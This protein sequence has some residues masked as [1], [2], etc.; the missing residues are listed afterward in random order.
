MKFFFLVS[1]SLGNPVRR[2]ADI[3]HRLLSEH[4]LTWDD[5]LSPLIPILNNSSE[6]FN[7][8]AASIAMEKSDEI[9]WQWGFW[10]FTSI[11]TSLVRTGSSS[12][13]T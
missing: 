11:T 6:A 4:S 5:D 3:K 2:I 9:A 1:L 8:T 13:A 10:P 7:V 12:R